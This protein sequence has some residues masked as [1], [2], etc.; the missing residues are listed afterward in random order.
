MNHPQL[1]YFNIR[2]YAL[3]FNQ[4]KELLVNDEVYK[5]I[6]MTKFPGGG[7][8]LGEGTID[9][10]KRE[11]MEELGVEIEV[12]EH[13]YTTD[14]YQQALFFEDQQL[15]SIYYRAKFKA[16]ELYKASSKPFEFDT[17]KQG[18]SFRWI[19]YQDLSP[20]LFT[21]PIDK[22]VVQMIKNEV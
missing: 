5:G 14:F 10:L 12:G 21:L 3:I 7:L 9:C 1:K 11:A 17:S 13:F 15:I 16:P 8:E 4:A 19:K 2:V 20:D 22:K 18:L 6:F